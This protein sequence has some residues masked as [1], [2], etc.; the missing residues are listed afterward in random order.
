MYS[1]RQKYIENIIQKSY[2]DYCNFIL[3]RGLE[4]MDSNTAKT[5]HITL[6]KSDQKRIG[7]YYASFDHCN[8]HYCDCVD[9]YS[10]WKNPKKKKI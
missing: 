5:S 1:K 8:N 3:Q 4:R 2:N 7:S 10:L 9:N 6:K